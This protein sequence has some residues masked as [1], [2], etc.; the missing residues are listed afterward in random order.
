MDTGLGIL[1]FEIINRMIETKKTFSFICHTVRSFQV[2]PTLKERKNK[3]FKLSSKR[4]N[5]FT[6]SHLK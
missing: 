1:I 4:L 2:L 3:F 5:Q 6:H